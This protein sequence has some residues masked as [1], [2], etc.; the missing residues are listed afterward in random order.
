MSIGRPHISLLLP[1]LLLVVSPAPG[2]APLT[3]EK[4]QELRNKA[5]TLYQ[6]G[7]ELSNRGR[8]QEAAQALEENLK[9][10]RELFPADR[11]PQGHP[12]LAT[13]IGSLGG[14]LHMGGQYAKA[15]AYYQQALAMRQAVYPRDKYPQGHPDLV[16]SLDNLGSVLQIQGNLEGAYV[17]LQQMLEMCRALYPKDKYPDGHRQL[18]RALTLQ[19]SHFQRTGELE[20]ALAYNQQALAMQQALFPKDKFPQGHAD[21]AVSLNSVAGILNLQARY[22]QALDY[23][24]QALKMRQDLYP[25]DKYPQGH[26]QIVMSLNEVGAILGYQGEYG[27]ALDHFEQSY[28]MC[29]ALYPKLRY[30]RG[31]PQLAEGL[32]KIG[33]VLLLRGDYPKA[34][35]YL[36][37]AAAAWRELYPKDLYPNGHNDLAR[38]LGNLGSTLGRAQRYQEAVP[39]FEETVAMLETLYPKERFPLGHPELANVLSNLGAALQHTGEFDKGLAVLQ[40][41]LKM[42]Q[43][44]FPKPSYPQGHPDLALN[45]HTLGSLLHAKKDDRESL[46][47]LRQAL[48]MYQDEF[49]LFASQASEA[50]AFNFLSRSP[51]TMSLMLSVAGA[52]QSPADEVYADIWRSKAAIAQLLEQRQVTLLASGDERTR[53]LSQELLETRRQVA[54]LLLAPAGGPARLQ[55]LNELTRRKEELERQ[56]VQA[57][58]ELARR[59]VLAR[60]P[61]TELTRRLPPRCCVV[62]FYLYDRDVKEWHCAA[63][64]LRPG[65][66]T[67]RVELG[68]IVPIHQAVD[69]WRREIAE[70]DGNTK[71]ALLRRLVWEPLVPHLPA[72]TETVYVVPDGPLGRLPW[73]ALPGRK[74]GTIL[75]EDHAVAVVPHGPFLLERLSAD[76][77]LGQRSEVVLTVGGVDYGATPTPVKPPADL[78][79]GARAPELGGKAVTWAPL[80]GTQREVDRVIELAGK[81]SV[82]ARRGAEASTAQLL[83]DLAN[84]TQPPRW[85]HLATHGFFADPLFRSALLMDSRAFERSKDRASPGARSPLVLSGVVLAGANTTPKSPQDDNG[86][87]TAEAIAGLPLRQLDL[88]VL[89]ACETGLGE[90]AGGEGV[91]GLQ[92]AFHLAGTHNVVASLWKVNDDATAALMALFY[93]KL[94]RENK[95]PLAALREAQLTL[96]RHP[97]RIAELAAERGPKFEQTVKLPSAPKPADQKTTPVKLWAAFVLSG[98][99]RE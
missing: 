65:Q 12:D 80:P 55:R 23:A 39:Y 45:L 71:A 5:I 66:A 6:Q 35:G 43:A 87:L 2:V 98:L 89:S 20:K 90:V 63:F 96:Y 52:L 10:A 53:Q 47:Y 73:A 83:A 75:L 94:W 85:V 50:E 62:D 4:E 81:R 58:P 54:R 16:V 77:T 72:D 40:R 9:I 64:V 46:A 1:I 69:D 22:P 78:V 82:V 38:S 59:Q 11:Y 7:F 49:D 93:H 67:Q 97:E 8:F 68:P 51:K 79:A 31:H 27:A 19:G 3:P 13:A 15:Q 74:S 14:V 76:P 17:Y 30:P 44:F 24:R 32:N 92:R 33:A 61:H 18:A 42:R 26:P 99:G 91:L 37:Q 36:Q 88:V 56:L 21:L 57:V 70:Q 28:A 48:A 86:I 41:A 34:L 95:P 25:K 29:Q 84:R 60:Q